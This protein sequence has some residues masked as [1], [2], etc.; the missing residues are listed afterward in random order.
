MVDVHAGG[1]LGQSSIQGWRP[2]DSCIYPSWKHWPGET[3]WKI[4]MNTMPDRV[5]DLLLMQPFQSRRIS[6]YWRKWNIRYQSLKSCCAMKQF[7]KI[8]RG[9]HFVS[10]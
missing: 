9:S 5:G 3:A 7:F 8:V 1:K 6:G 2:N 10:V 4:A